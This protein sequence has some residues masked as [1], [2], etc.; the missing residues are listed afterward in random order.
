MAVWAEQDEIVCV[1]PQGPR[2]VGHEAIAASY[3][4]IFSSGMSLK[5]ELA[6]S[7][8]YQTQALAVHCVIEMLTV[9]GESEAPPPIAATNV[10]ALTDNGWR[11]VAHH[12]GAV[13]FAGSMPE[14][15]Q[16]HTLH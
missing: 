16:T 4:A 13:P 6:Q 2:L 10:F 15:S 14:D 7:H 11:L 12:A 3:K 8:Q 9:K 5:V 1:H